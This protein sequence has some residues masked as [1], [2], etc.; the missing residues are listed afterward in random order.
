MALIALS[1]KRTF[2]ASVKDKGVIISEW[3][4][5]V[6][7]L[8]PSELLSTTLETFKRREWRQTGIFMYVGAPRA[9][10]RGLGARLMKEGLD[11]VRTNKDPKNVSERMMVRAAPPLSQAGP[12]EP[13]KHVPRLVRT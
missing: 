11:W 13:D 7:I 12:H 10:G 8:R 5:M 2:I 9:Q 6:S 3:V 4:R 1:I